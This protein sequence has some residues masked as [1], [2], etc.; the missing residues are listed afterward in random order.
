MGSFI[1]WAYSDAPLAG[2]AALQF[3]I[4]LQLRV[5][6]GAIIFDTLFNGRKI[7]LLHCAGQVARPISMTFN[8]PG[9]SAGARIKGTR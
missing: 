5:C 3:K 1:F 9:T 6:P 2:S 7:S 8:A 4:K